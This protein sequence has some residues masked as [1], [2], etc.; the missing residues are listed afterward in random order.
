MREK[1][2]APNITPALIPNK[3]S[4][5][6]VEIFLKKKIGNAPMH[7]AKKVTEVPIRM[8]L[9]KELEAKVTR[10]ISSLLV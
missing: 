10:L 2:T 3:I 5:A 1:Q 7:E 6:F 8:I 4:L 9:K